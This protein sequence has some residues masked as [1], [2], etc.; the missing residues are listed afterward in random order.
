M[1]EKEMVEKRGRSIVKALSWRFLATVTTMLAVYGFTGEATLSLGI[2][3][4]DLFVKLALYYFHERTWNTIAWGK[5]E[6][7]K[8]FS[9]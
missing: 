3:A 4:V 8:Q 2:G 7:S 6:Y 1:W 9:K 5:A